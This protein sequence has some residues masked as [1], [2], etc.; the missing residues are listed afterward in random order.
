MFI[1]TQTAVINGKRYSPLYLCKGWTPEKP[2]WSGDKSHA[3]RWLVELMAF[4]ARDQV[5]IKNDAYD[6]GVENELVSQNPRTLPTC[7]L[8]ETSS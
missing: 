2:I 5:F 4:V 7:E 8:G 6:Y 3:Q 1:V